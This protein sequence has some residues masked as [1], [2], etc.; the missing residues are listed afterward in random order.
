MMRLELKL[1]LAALSHM[2][3]FSMVE[4]SFATNPEYV[5]AHSLPIE[6]QSGHQL[7]L[8]LGIY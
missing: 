4:R 2:L 1:V 8:V 7:P 5:A 6:L 3:S